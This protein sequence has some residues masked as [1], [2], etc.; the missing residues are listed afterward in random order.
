MNLS[1]FE[2]VVTGSRVE[3]IPGASG[4]LDFTVQ[5][6]YKEVET[7]RNSI[8][9][10]LKAE[11]VIPIKNSFGLFSLGYEAGL[12]VNREITEHKLTLSFGIGDYWYTTRKSENIEDTF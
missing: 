8:V 12:S 11:L 4:P 7:P 5:Y 3:Q 10:P 2:Y 6:F 9:L 1:S